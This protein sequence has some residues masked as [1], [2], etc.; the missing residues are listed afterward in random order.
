LGLPCLLFAVVSSS[1]AQDK[2][3]IVEHGRYTVHMLLHPIGTEEYTVTELRPGHFVMNTTWTASDRG[4]KRTTTA[5][6]EMGAMSVPMRLEQ[7]ASPANPDGESLTEIKGSSASVRE[8]SESRKISRPAVAFVGF[9]TMPAAVQT[10]MMRYWK[11]HH[12]PTR[13]PIVRAS[14]KALPLEIKLVGHDVFASKGQMIRLTRYTVAN[15]MFGREILWMNDSGRLAAL[16]TFAGGLPQEEVL[17]GY[18]PVEAELERSGVRQEMLDLD[19]LDRQVPAE[20]KGSFAIVG[21]RLIDGTGAPAV[22]DSVVVVKDGRIAAVGAAGATRIPAGMRVIHAEGRSLLPGLWEMHLHYSGVEFGPALLAAGVTT[23]RDCGGESEFLTTLRGKIDTDH[24]LGPKLLLA[25]LIDSGGPL[26]FGYVNVKT[27]AEGV[28][29]V[30]T[31]ADGKFD[32]IK[33]YSQLQPDV[34]KAIAAEAHRRGMTVTGHVPNAMNA[35]E[36]V[37][38]GMDQINHLQ[39]V[40]R[41]MVP[42]HSKGPVDVGRRERRS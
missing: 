21:A 38:D 40:T 24:A 37:A 13:L 19:D 22:E 23:A 10:M 16:M 9:G 2:P 33:V 39:Y 25:G 11:A 3:L 12:Q 7:T 29:A 28:E 34:L 15:L 14:D 20:A 35:F 1:K 30:D 36:G 8:G 26:G 5:T 41:A 17:D 32:Q 18:Q 27:P 4:T 42:D 6:L 31:Y